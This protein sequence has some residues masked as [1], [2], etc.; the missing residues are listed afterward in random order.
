MTVTSL[1]GVYDADGGLLGEAAY[2]WGRLRGT[3]HCALCD[4]THSAVRRKRAWDAT[5]ARLGVPF[6]L[7]HLN[8]MPAD[9]AAVVRESGAPV[10]LARTGDGVVPLVG[11]DELETAGGSVDAFVQL[12]EERLVR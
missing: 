4:I 3:R 1:I 7:L 2:V 11:A 10:V 12:V 9:V 5:V 8:E 6:D